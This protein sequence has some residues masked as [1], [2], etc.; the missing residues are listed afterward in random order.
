MSVVESDN[1]E[2]LVD[3]EPG[4][5]PDGKIEPF[6]PFEPFVSLGLFG[7]RLMGSGL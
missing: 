2:P 5:I 6:E 4:A 3:G 1:L 7:G